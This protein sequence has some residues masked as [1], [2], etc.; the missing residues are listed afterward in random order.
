[1]GT[2]N[3]DTEKYVDAYI[4]EHGKPP[5]FKQVQAY[6]NLQNRQIAR[7]RCIKFIGKMKTENNLSSL[8]VLN[9]KKTQL[10]IYER[11]SLKG[12]M[13]NKF[14]DDCVNNNVSISGLIR[15]CVKYYYDN[16]EKRKLDILYKNSLK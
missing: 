5:T 15:E 16:E 12:E 14:L 9:K 13:K 4:L 10:V 3:K 1:M 11:I 8:S 7:G 2:I 6:F